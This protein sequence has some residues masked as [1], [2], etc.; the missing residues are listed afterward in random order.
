MHTYPVART[1]SGVL[2]ALTLHVDAAQSPPLA[3]HAAHA[4]IL[5][6]RHTYSVELRSMSGVRGAVACTRARCMFTLFQICAQH[7]TR[8]QCM[9]TTNIDPHETRTAADMWHACVRHCFHAVA[10]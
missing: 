8:A 10:D 4:S 9:R 6:I 7:A 3:A 1:A 5:P 2:W